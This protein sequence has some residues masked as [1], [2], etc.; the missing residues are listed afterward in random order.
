MDI[1]MSSFRKKK[2]LKALPVKAM[3]KSDWI[4]SYPGLTTLTKVGR[5]VWP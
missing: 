4:I 1:T 5:R 2:L 3:V